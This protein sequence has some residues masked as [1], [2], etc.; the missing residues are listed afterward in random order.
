[1]TAAAAGAVALSTVAVVTAVPASAH[2]T[3]LP[4]AAYYR[5][6]VTSISPPTP[7]LK[8]ELSTGGETVTLTNET[9]S[10]VMV[11]GYEGEDY[12]RITPTGVDQNTNSLSAF[13]NGTLV[14]QGLPQQLGQTSPDQPPVW[15]HVADQPAYS[16][17]DH[18]V[19]WMAQQ[20][21]P[22]VAADPS[23][24]Q[25]VFDWAMQLKVGDRPVTVHGSLDWIGHSGL[26][27]LPLALT[28]LLAVVVG[29]CLAIVLLRLHLKRR[30]ETA[31]RERSLAEPP[32]LAPGDYVLP[33]TPLRVSLPREG[34]DPDRNG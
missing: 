16:W 31:A 33:E 3:T 9:G 25:H 2:D 21:P 28:V 19:H 24:P 30:E 15:K 6:T 12:L 23:H 26:T 10:T 20:Q 22:V 32:L 14:I 34:P 11:L 8:V 5:S 13:L 18:R 4:D 17:H 1:M 27:G 7:G 29:L